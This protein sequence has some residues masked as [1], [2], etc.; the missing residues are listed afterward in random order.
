MTG[1]IGETQVI[2]PVTGQIPF[3]PGMQTETSDTYTPASRHARSGRRHAAPRRKRRVFAYVAKPGEWSRRRMRRD[4]RLFMMIV[5]CAAIL[6]AA[7][8]LLLAVI[9]SNL[10]TRI[11]IVTF[12]IV[13][14]IAAPIPMIRYKK[15]FRF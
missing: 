2:A 15:E 3:K 11:L 10:S 8:M 4:L 13:G 6:Y 7:G 1:S 5:V 14:G 12:A 9:I